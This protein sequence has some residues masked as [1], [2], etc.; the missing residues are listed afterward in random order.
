MA[1]TFPTPSQ[2][3]QRRLRSASEN[4]V[5]PQEWQRAEEEW[6]ELLR[7]PGRK[8]NMNAVLDRIFFR[9]G[10]AGGDGEAWDK[11]KRKSDLIMSRGGW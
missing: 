6:P 1:G 11:L 2:S 9:N 5:L 3:H 4:L 8:E 7:D 10:N